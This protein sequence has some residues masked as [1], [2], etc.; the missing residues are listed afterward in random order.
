MSGGTLIALAADETIMDPDAV[1]GPLDPQ[2]QTPK[3]TFPAPSLIKIA[4]MKGDKASDDTLIYADIAEKALREIQEFI[5]QLLKDKMPEEKAFEVAKKLT[6]GYYTHDYPIT[7]EHAKE[8]GLPVK[9]DVPQEVYLLMNL[10]PQAIQ[11][12]PGVEYIPR[13]HIPYYH[14]KHER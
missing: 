6:E 4:K 2:L 11:Q 8:L 3:G 9:T 5:V 14:G 1:L 12:R 10:Y 13:P 7:V